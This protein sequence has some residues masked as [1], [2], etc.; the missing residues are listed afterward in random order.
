VCAH[1]LSATSMVVIGVG[2]HECCRSSMDV[3][4]FKVC[5]S[6]AT[7]SNRVL[8]DLNLLSWCQKRVESTGEVVLCLKTVNYWLL[9]CGPSNFRFC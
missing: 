5:L 8:F 1:P 3:K 4:L 7:V 2:L 6:R 9:R